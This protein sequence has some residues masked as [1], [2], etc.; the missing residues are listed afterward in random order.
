MHLNH[1]RVGSGEPLVLIHGIGHRWQAWLP[2]IDH[3]KPHREVIALDLPGFAG[4]PMPPPGTP[5]GIASLTS[6]V[7][8]FLDELNLE[9]PHVAGN[10]LGGWISLELAKQ[11]RVRSAT[12]LSP[13][14]FHNRLEGVFQRSSLV[15]A[16]W[17]S[18]L[19]A[20]RAARILARPGVRRLAFNQFAA[21]PERIPL[22]EIVP[23]VRDL[24]HA[25]WF[26][27]TLAAIN[28]APFS[29]GEQIAV[30]VT[31]AWGERDRLLLPHQA[32]RAARAIPSARSLT[33]SGCGHL[34]FYD[35]PQQ[36][37]QVLLQASGA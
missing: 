1:L 9:R 36:V 12:A 28:R 10:S 32:K 30:P 11:N 25:P 14:G 5:A 37:A 35:D 16:S 22:A 2:V 6:L 18:R 3:L 24:V 33:L 34:P 8:D 26:D 15:L 31:I 23:V 19:I 21:H 4:S 20:P 17:G 27:E 13:A 29:G 7:G